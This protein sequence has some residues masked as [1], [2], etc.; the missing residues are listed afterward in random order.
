M[1][2]L[3]NTWV[4]GEQYAH[5]DQNAVA[6]AVNA[7]TH[8]TPGVGTFAS[9]PAAGNTN[10]IYYSQNNNNVYRDN[11]TSWD[12]VRIGADSCDAM[13]DV[14]TTGWTAVNM[15]SGAAFASDKDA[16]LFTVPSTGVGP[17][18]QYQYRGYPG[19]PF[20]LTAYIDA[21][22]IVINDGGWSAAGIV[23]SDGTKL[24]TLGPEY[25]NAGVG[26]SAAGWNVWAAK[27]ANATTYSSTYGTW[28]VSRFEVMPKW[29]RFTDDGTNF[30]WQVSVNGIDWITIGGPEARTSFLTPTRIGLGG[31]NYTGNGLLMRVRSWNGVS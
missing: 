27:F 6:N 24:I 22:Q 15:Q 23:I 13:G 18:W 16:M 28:P 5:T 19:S 9:R 4:L 21:A 12:K 1:T 2:D 20:V 25:A 14:P 3:K 30:T 8:A 7:S 29:Y 10:A 26:A 17:N 31:S 11:G